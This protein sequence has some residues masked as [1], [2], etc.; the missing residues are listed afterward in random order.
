VLIT[1][2]ISILSNQ[3]AKYNA[4]DQYH[5]LFGF[6]FFCDFNS[7]AYACAEA[8]SSDHTF[9]FYPPTNLIQ[10]L[11]LRPIRLFLP[12]RH[13]FIQKSK[14]AL[15][16][17]THAPFV[18]AVT[19]FEQIFCSGN[20]ERRGTTSM[21]RPPSSRSAQAA[22]N[23]ISIYSQANPKSDNDVPMTTEE[24]RLSS[25][26]LTDIRQQMTKLEEDMLTVK[27]LLEDILSKI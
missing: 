17:V 4:R 9:D 12:S 1:V 21:L 25:P 6:N 14:F 5:F 3:F 13:P 24:G 16:R 8:I 27:R 19:I 10:L 23:R 2:L 26:D 22:A 11:L 18:L 20:G 7:P 15:L